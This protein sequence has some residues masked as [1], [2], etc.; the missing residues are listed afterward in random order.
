MPRASVRIVG[1][2]PVKIPM[3]G[4]AR[5]HLDTPAFVFADKIQLELSEPP[6]GVS[7][8]TVGPQRGGGTEIVLQCDATKAKAGLK[9]N[10]IV[11]AVAGKP[12]GAGKGKLQQGNKRPLSTL[13]AI[14]FEIVLR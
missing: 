11:S 2:S 9:G 12:A 1:E 8:K 3:G 14:P 4:T 13:P 6:D 10:L 5:V 7:I